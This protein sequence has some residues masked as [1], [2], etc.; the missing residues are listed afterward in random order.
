MRL[1]TK[2]RLQVVASIGA[3]AL[4]LGL[5]AGVTTSTVGSA[6]AH[7]DAPPS[8]GL[9]EVATGRVLD[10]RTGTGGYS[11]P[12]ST[13]FHSVAVVGVGGLPSSGIAAVQVNLMVIA[14]T[15]SGVIYADADGAS[16]PNTSV[17][18]VD[19]TATSNSTIYSN[20]A[21]IP[22]G[23]DGKIE[24]EPTSSVD[25]VIDVQ[26]YYTS[27][28]TAAGGYVPVDAAVIANTATGDGGVPAAEVPTGGVITAQVGGLG[29][30][31]STASAVVLGVQETSPSANP[32]ALIV[33][34]TGSTQPQGGLQWAANHSGSWTT[35][36]ALPTSGQVNIKV[37]SGGSVDVKAEVEGYF[38]STSGSA[39]AGTFTP[40][41][42]RVY[43]SRQH[44]SLGSGQTNTVQVAGVGGVPSIDS[45]ILAVAV[46]ITVLPGTSSGHLEAFADDASPIDSTMYFSSSYNAVSGFAVVT[47]GADGGIDLQNSSPGSIDYVVDVEGWYHAPDLATPTVSCPAPYSNGSVA[48][49][50]PTSA[51]SCTVS[52]ANNGYGSTNGYLDT[53]L[54]G[55]ELTAAPFS[56]GGTTSQTVSVPAQGGT[57]SISTTADSSYGAE[58][59]AASYGFTIPGPSTPISLAADP[60]VTVPD[61]ND[62]NDP[63]ATNFAPTLFASTNDASQATTTF[64][65]RA[66]ETTDPSSLVQTCVSPAVTNGESAACKVQPLTEGTYYVRSQSS[67]ATYTSAWSDWFTLPVS[68]TANKEVMAPAIVSCPSMVN[69]QWDQTPPTD[70]LTCQV[71]AAA[72]P[73]GSGALDIT[74]DG[75]ALP[76]VALDPTATTTVPVVIPAGAAEHDIET[77]VQEVVDGPSTSSQS[78]TFG[79]GDWSDANLV[80]NIADGTDS[81]D[82]APV[83]WVTTDGAPVTSDSTYQY[84]LATNS[85]GSGAIET[86][87]S[88]ATFTIPDGT[89]TTGTTYYW[90]VQ[91]QGPSNYGGVTES[92]TSPWYSFVA[93]ADPNLE[94]GTA[95]PAAQVMAAQ[96][97]STAPTRCGTVDLLT[98]RGTLA[99]GGVT[100]TDPY[101]YKNLSG[102]GVPAVNDGYG[103][104]GDPEYKLVNTIRASSASPKIFTEAIRYD[105]S[106]AWGISVQTGLN[107]LTNELNSIAKTCPS[108]EVILSGHSQGAYVIDVL[109]DSSS[110]FMKLTA[111]ARMNLMGIA[112]LGDPSYYTGEK[113]DASGNGKTN[114]TFI[115]GAAQRPKYSYDKSNSFRSYSTVSKTIRLDVRSWCMPYDL[116]CQ[117]CQIGSATYVTCLT[118]DRLAIHNNYG[119]AA[120]VSSQLAFLRQ[121]IS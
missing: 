93:T 33:Y 50:V 112:L 49:S 75:Q 89:L 18:Y 116:Y 17:T 95:A 1:R 14:P 118:S 73:D 32:G 55:V 20:S 100:T 62:P 107:A 114:G 53:Y 54:D 28:P 47:L 31:P 16:T 23:A 61:P 9:F 35:T 108:T 13:T 4:A 87:S 58:S 38:T 64:E 103:N 60:W 15:H 19:Y 57:H 30:V 25:L 67:D 76:E 5:L 52:V 117:T 69:G 42:G 99:P 78:F 26:G 36:V 121:F 71:T 3:A 34:P 111:K 91:I 96:S 27:G 51:V 80:P 8:G 85:D 82:L 98:L 104:K 84:T 45:G 120:I 88:A 37:T 7:A 105:A 109:T 113:I 12:L 72:A 79:S 90:N 6:P 59:D 86:S 48:S 63:S 43:D 40:L 65:I 66:A 77:S 46:D 74:L 39:Q 94:S 83:I 56:S 92:L 44:T 110:N 29:G 10:T 70:P 24:V 21:I 102:Y 22:V 101:I 119:S 68:S 115:G 2:S 81:N 97:A 11:G 106:V 41:A